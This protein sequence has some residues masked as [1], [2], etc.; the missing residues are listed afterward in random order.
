MAYANM[1]LTSTRSRIN[2]VGMTSTLLSDVEKFLAETGMH[3]QQF[4]KKAAGNARLV[5]RLSSE[6]RYGKGRVW[7]ETEMKIRVY[8]ASHKQ[9][10]AA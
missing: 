9:Q 7:P 4:G 8:M 3:P 6:T 1:R 5:E 2:V 10:A